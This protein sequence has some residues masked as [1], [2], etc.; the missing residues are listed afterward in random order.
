MTRIDGSDETMTGEQI[1][2]AIWDLIDV[3]EPV[4]FTDIDGQ[5]YDVLID[6]YR[7]QLAP[8]LPQINAGSVGWE[9]A[10]QLRLIQ[11]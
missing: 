9:L 4:V 2:A 11:V 3:N 5:E 6:E 8:S 7:E 10:G 1:S